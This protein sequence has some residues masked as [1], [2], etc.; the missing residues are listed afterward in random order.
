M[1][2][3]KFTALD[4]IFASGLFGIHEK[5]ITRGDGISWLDKSATP[6]V[7]TFYDEVRKRDCWKVAVSDTKDWAPFK[8]KGLILPALERAD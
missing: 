8:E 3:D 2:G 7:V 4:L 1:L 6:R 5:C